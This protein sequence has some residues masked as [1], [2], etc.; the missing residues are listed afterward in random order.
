MSKFWIDRPWF[1]PYYWRL[2]FTQNKRIH[3][4]R[5]RLP[6]FLPILWSEEEVLLF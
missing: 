4:W 3:R 2:W 1:S 5:S 6:I